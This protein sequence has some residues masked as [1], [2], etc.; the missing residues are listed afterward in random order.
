MIWDAHERLCHAMNGNISLYGYIICTMVIICLPC[1]SVVWIWWCW[2]NLMSSLGLWN[3]HPHSM[4]IPQKWLDHILYLLNQTLWQLLF[5]STVRNR[6]LIPG[7]IFGWKFW[8]INQIRSVFRCYQVE[9]Y[10]AISLTF[11]LKMI[12]SRLIFFNKTPTNEWNDGL[13]IIH[14]QIQDDLK[15]K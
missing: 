5:F 11:Y 9:V 8:L 3:H 12:S 7:S 14:L 4:L 15:L 6:I 13:S 2:H 10:T 1:I